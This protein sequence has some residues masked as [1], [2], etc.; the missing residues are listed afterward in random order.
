MFKDNRDFKIFGFD[1]KSQNVR[2]VFGKYIHSGTTTLK[3]VLLQSL[4]KHKHVYK[5]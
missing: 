3:R 4:K 2:N 1:A 5:M